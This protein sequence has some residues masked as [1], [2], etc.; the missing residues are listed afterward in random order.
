MYYDRNS[1]KYCLK[2]EKDIALIGSESYK[3]FKEMLRDNYGA[4]EKPYFDTLQ[5]MI[6]FMPN[7]RITFS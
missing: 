6:I 1:S 2:N 7:K 5:K 4:L 3:M